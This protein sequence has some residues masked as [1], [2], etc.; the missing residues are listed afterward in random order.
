MG[1]Y[2]VTG[3]CGFIGSHLTERLLKDGH[4]VVIVD[5]LSTGQRENVPKDV[6]VIVSSICDTETFKDEIANIDGCIHLA[7]VSS[8]ERSRVDWLGT[9]KANLSG[10][11][12][13]MDAIAKSP[14][15]GMPISYA[16]SAAVYGDNEHLPLAETSA[17]KPL[18]AYGADKLGCEQHAFI[19]GVTHGLSTTGFRFFNIYGPRQD[20]SSP[21]S[22]VISIFAKRMIDGEAV[23]IFGDGEQ[24]RDFVYVGDAVEALTVSLKRDGATSAVFNVC[25]GRSITINSLMWTLAQILD[26]EQ[27]A[28]YADAR[29]GEI[30]HSLGDATQLE[31]VLGVKADTPLTLGLKTTTDWMKKTRR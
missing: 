10:F 26:Y 16:S 15:A 6:Q 21:Y 4:D 18:S 22:G 5:D 17:T 30:R 8:V 24:T 31:T 11:V 27:P 12:G 14:R 7:A 1:R 28:N 19:G 25:S 29:P 23:T 13:L 9:H 2:L 20:P 3:G